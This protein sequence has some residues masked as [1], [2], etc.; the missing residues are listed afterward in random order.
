MDHA[1]AIPELL[2]K[3]LEY[4]SADELMVA[5]LVCRA[6][7]DPVVDTEWRT[8]T[9]ML[10]RLLARLAPIRK[11]TRGRT[12][13]AIKSPI[14]QDHWTWFLKHYA[15]RITKL[16][17]DMELDKSSVKSYPRY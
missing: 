2:I 12:V 15:N 13:L 4:L 7:V 11:S 1:L 14:T 16:E 9:I 3:I 5:A 10:S 17:F 8:Q 6:W